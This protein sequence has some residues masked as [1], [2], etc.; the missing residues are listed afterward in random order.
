MAS[1][2]F[3]L[4][5]LTVIVICTGILIGINI[6]I[7]HIYLSNKSALETD[8]CN[9]NSRVFVYWRTPVAGG[10]AGQDM[11]NVRKKNLADFVGFSHILKPDNKGDYYSICTRNGEIRL[12]YVNSNTVIMEGM[13]KALKRG[14]HPFIKSQLNLYTFAVHTSIGT[15]KGF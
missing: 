3:I 10:G 15:A 11:I 8:M 6:Y 4:L 9:Y 2:R 1:F 14:N 7:N 12:V 13:G 5:I